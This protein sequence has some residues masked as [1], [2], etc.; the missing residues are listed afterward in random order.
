MKGEAPG[1]Q[2]P[3]HINQRFSD[4]DDVIQVQT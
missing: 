2:Q 4:I 1:T 3:E